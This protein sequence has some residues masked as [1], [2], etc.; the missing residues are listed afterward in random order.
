MRAIR[1]IFG[2]YSVLFDIP[3]VISCVAF[4]GRGSIGVACQAVVS[5]TRGLGDNREV[6]FCCERYVS[7]YV[8]FGGQCTVFCTVKVQAICES[9]L[10][11][12]VSA[13]CMEQGGWSV[14]VVGEYAIFVESVHGGFCIPAEEAEGS[15]VD[16]L[17]SGVPVSKVPCFVSDEVVENYEVDEVVQV[18]ILGDCAVLAW[19]FQA[20]IGERE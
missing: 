10:E 7:K 18:E 4:E 1:E 16:F 13:Q 6:Y 17:S 11:V 19:V 15:V 20:L 5:P 14:G 3:V 12:R 2:K 9:F 8:S